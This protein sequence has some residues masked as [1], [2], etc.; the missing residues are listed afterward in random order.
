MKLNSRKEKHSKIKIGTI[1]YHY[2]HHQRHHHHHHH[3]YYAQELLSFF[4]LSL[5]VNLIYDTNCIIVDKI[6]NCVGR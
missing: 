4:I 3:H 2:H 5:L 6:E 1:Y